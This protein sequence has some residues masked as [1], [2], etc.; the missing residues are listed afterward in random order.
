MFCF[1]VLLQHLVSEQHRNF[2]RENNHYVNLDAMIDQGPNMERFLDDVMQHHEWQRIE[3]IRSVGMY[4][5]ILGQ[6]DQALCS[7]RYAELV[8]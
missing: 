8:I 3:G 6:S 5:Y 1:P 7:A 2:V 4:I